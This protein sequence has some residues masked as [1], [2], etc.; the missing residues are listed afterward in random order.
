MGFDFNSPWYVLG[1]ELA[2]VYAAKSVI[3]YWEV[4]LSSDFPR[5]TPPF[6]ARRDSGF[7]SAGS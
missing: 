4:Y 2:F 1:P 6:R 5:D 7:G 3:D